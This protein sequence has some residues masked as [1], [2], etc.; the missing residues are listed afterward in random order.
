MEQFLPQTI[1]D[2][3]TKARGDIEIIVV[4][5]GYWPVQPIERDNL[6][7][8]T[9]H[10]GGQHANYG[11]RA[12]INLGA[13]VATGT[14]LM[15]VDEHCAFDE[16]YDT[17]L[18][19]DCDDDWLVTPRRY[20]LD[21]AS[22]SCITNG[23]R[24]PIDNMHPMFPYID[25]Q[26]WKAR[27]LFRQD[28]LIDDCFGMQ[29]SCWLMS[30]KHFDR[31]GGMDEKLYGKFHF[32]AQELCFKTWLGGGRVITN[33]KT[34][35]AHRHR[36]NKEGRQYGFSNKQN[37]ELDGNQVKEK[38][39]NMLTDYWYQDQWPDAK[40]KFE[41]LINKFWP[42]PTWPENWKEIYAKK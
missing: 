25:F 19:A 14:H 13:K 7:V 38:L 12:S 40:L 9:L 22:W 21:E 28:K 35:Y 20:R 1:N 15:K 8:I 41:W 30:R 3:L 27:Y 26:E 29:G 16:G 24:P 37:R 39:G 2:L 11:M 23:G 5:D 34:Y 33:K 4:L 32:E 42:I 31:L 10:H 36:S 18:L 6:K 17:K